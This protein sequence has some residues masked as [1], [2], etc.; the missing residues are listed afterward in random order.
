MSRGRL[1]AKIQMSQRRSKYN[2]S[3]TYRSTYWFVTYLYS[4]TYKVNS[5]LKE[6]KFCL[7]IENSIQSSNSNN[8]YA[9]DYDVDYSTEKLTD[10]IVGG[11]IPIYYGP[12][13]IFL[14]LPNN[15][16]A[17]LLGNIYHG[18]QATV[19]N[20]INDSHQLI[21]FRN[22]GYANGYINIK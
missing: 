1:Y 5:T 20:G 7:A 16:I 21:D 4:T 2:N 9:N 6:Y 18:L 10:C 12:K 3:K 11:S 22:V 8:Y 14:F 17:I 19:I 13:T 15:N